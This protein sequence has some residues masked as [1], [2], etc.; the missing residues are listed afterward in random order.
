MKKGAGL[1]LFFILA[2]PVK[3]GSVL[4]L[5]PKYLPN[6]FSKEKKQAFSKI[7]NPRFPGMQKFKLLA[8]SPKVPIPKP[9]SM[10]TPPEKL[11]KTPRSSSSMPDTSRNS[12]VLFQWL[13]EQYASFQWAYG[14]LQED[15][16]YAPDLLKEKITEKFKNDTLL[17]LNF[18]QNIIQFPYVLKWGIRGSVGRTR[19]ADF[20]RSSFFPLSVSVITSLQIFKRQIIVPFF[21]LGYSVWNVNF[22]DFS[23]W[24]PFYGAGMLISFSLFKNSLYHTLFDEYGIRDTGIIVELRNNASPLDFPEKDRGYFLRSLHLG[25]YLQF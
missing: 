5:F 20:E 17:Y 4:P 8:E 7:K 19:N 22:S 23:K 11:I 1:V 15:N 3:A 2:G 21:E 12:L 16:Q 6:T 24:F 9:D 10:T 18:H 13:N 14:F 25:V